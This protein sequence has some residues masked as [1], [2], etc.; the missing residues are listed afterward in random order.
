MKIKTEQ[1]AP[2]IKRSIQIAN[3][4]TPDYINED[5][6]DLSVDALAFRLKLISSEYNCYINSWIGGN[7]LDTD[8]GIAECYMAGDYI[9]EDESTWELITAESEPIAIIA[10]FKWLA[11]R[12]YLVPEKK[13]VSDE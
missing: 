7:P 8:R 2:I 5:T 13:V 10:S 12:G 9:E 11:D 6:Y 1:I 4:L 3:E